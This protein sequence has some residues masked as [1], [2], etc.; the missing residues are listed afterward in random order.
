MHIPS[1]YNLCNNHVGLF[2][3]VHH[4]RPRQKLIA[5]S[6]LFLAIIFI[7]TLASLMMYILPDSGRN[8]SMFVQRNLSKDWLKSSSIS[9]MFGFSVSQSVWSWHDFSLE[10]SNIHIISGPSMFIIPHDT[11]LN[12][13]WSMLHVL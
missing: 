6:L 1:A 10:H 2:P 5:K 12:R 9:H 3:Y 4:L 7:F 13:D 8:L 11:T